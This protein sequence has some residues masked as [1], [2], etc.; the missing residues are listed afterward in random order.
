MSLGRA[1]MATNYSASTE[2]I[3]VENGYPIS[4]ASI[5]VNDPSGTYSTGFWGEPSIQHASNTIRWIYNHPDDRIK[6]SA[7]AKKSITKLNN[8][9]KRSVISKSLWY[10]IVNYT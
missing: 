1:V 5:P 2:F 6:K 10:S 8:K 7:F 3:N 4:V 9:W